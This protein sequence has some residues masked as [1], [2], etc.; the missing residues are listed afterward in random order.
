MAGA[1]TAQQAGPWWQGFQDPAL[2]RLV[3]AVLGWAR[4]DGAQAVALWV[5]DGYERARRFY[6]R[7]GFRPTGERGPLPRAVVEQIYPRFRFRALFGRE[8]SLEAELRLEPG[9]SQS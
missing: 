6:T 7:L 2:D 3:E 8:I 5:V 4:E 1:L 9:V